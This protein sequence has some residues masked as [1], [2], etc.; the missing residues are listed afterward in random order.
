MAKLNRD[1][2]IQ[3]PPM[4]AFIQQPMLVISRCLLL[5]NM[6]TPDEEDNPNWDEEIKSDV[7]EECSKF[8]Q[9]H[10][11]FVEKYSQVIK[12]DV[13]YSFITYTC[14]QIVDTFLSIHRSTIHYTP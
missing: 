9:I 6:F 4:P 10:H 12:D 14:T 5:K 13:H 7:M 3:A 1:N 2:A 11:I 8:G